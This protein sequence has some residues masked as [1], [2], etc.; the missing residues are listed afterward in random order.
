LTTA[1]KKSHLLYL[2]SGRL[3]VKTD[4]GKEE[5]FT[6]GDIGMIAPGHDGWAV[7][8]EPAIW[9]EIMR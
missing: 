8:N 5:E 2:I 1:I 6:P 7:G 3:H 4:D 9:L